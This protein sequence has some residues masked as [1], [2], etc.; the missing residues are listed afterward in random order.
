MVASQSNYLSSPAPSVC[1]DVSRR[2]DSFNFGRT[3]RPEI[4]E[5]LVQ[6]GGFQELYLWDVEEAHLKI[7]GTCC[8]ALGKLTLLPASYDRIEEL[9]QLHLSNLTALRV[10]QIEYENPQHW[11]AAFT[12]TNRVGGTISCRWTAI[13]W[14]W[15]LTE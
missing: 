10:V 14:S 1:T 12:L 15:H 3:F 11:R 2:L 8:T 5:P 9:L 6:H 13:R 4:L 7:L